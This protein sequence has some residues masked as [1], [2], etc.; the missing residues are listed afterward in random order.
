MSSSQGSPES[1]LFEV[2]ADG[3]SMRLDRFLA[4]AVTDC[5]RAFLQQ[6]ISKGSVLVGGAPA[7]PSL[8]LMQGQ[9]ILVELPEPEPTRAE[10]EPIPLDILYEDA[11]VI[12]VNKPAGMVVHPSYG[13]ERGTLVNALLHHCRDLSGVGGELRP[14]IVH[15]L[16]RDTSGVIAAAKSDRAHHGLADQFKS[17]SVRKTYLAIVHGSPR[18]EEDVIRAPLGRRKHHFQEIA[19]KRRGGKAAETRYRVLERFARFSLLEL[20]P[21]TGRTHQIRVH[22]SWIGHPV[23]CDPL[24][25]H[26]SRLSSSALGGEGEEEIISRHALHALVLELDHP[27]T[28]KR[29]RFEAEV[30]SDMAR[31]LK[32]LREAPDGS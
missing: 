14:G 4:G 2:P 12:V 11:A 7:K 21:L 26:E 20:H 29:L 6:L 1:L 31:A 5:S 23:L 25:G 15:R 24:Y 28:G 8:R 9:E 30:P 22:L 27:T 16:D 3:A 13:R 32:I 18:F 10:P 17:R 19:V